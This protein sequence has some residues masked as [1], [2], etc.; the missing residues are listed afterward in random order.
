MVD[1]KKPLRHISCRTKIISGATAL[2]IIGAA[3]GACA[4]A[5]TRPGVEMAPT[6][7]IP[8]ATLPQAS[9]VITLKG[10]VAEVF[11]TRFIVQDGS[12]R[13]LID[14]GPASA[15]IVRQGETLLVQGRYDEE[16]VRASYLVGPD[17]HIETVGPPV[18]PPHGPHSPGPGGPGRE[19]PPPP[20]S[21]P[22]SHAP[23]PAPSA[24]PLPPAASTS[25]PIGRPD[26]QSPP[27]R[28]NL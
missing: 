28:S 12:G 24:A 10:K 5:M 21:P 18:H 25:G 20:P 26:T 8:I 14:A 16:R 27:P 2:L 22:A 7:P 11:G 19:G 1:L 6:V 3:G 9:G 15:T 4:M 17:G 13:A 23:P